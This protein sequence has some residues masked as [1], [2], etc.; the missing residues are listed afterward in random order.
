MDLDRWGEAGCR[1]PP[2]RLASWVLSHELILIIVTHRA[3][4]SLQ[5]LYILLKSQ[6]S[7]V[8]LWVKEMCSI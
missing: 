6:R 7:S 2:M 8:S 5:R 4:L 3:L 1:E